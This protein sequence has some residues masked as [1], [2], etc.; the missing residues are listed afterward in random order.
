MSESESHRKKICE[1]ESDE[2]GRGR[3]VRDRERESDE[4]G[5][6]R[7]VRETKGRET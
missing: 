6:G 4:R 5:R 7:F 2:R 1:R 3:F